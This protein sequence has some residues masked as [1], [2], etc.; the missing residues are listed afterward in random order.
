MLRIYINQV[1]MD[2]K[3]WIWHWDTL[4]DDWELFLGVTEQN[5]NPFIKNIGFV[6]MK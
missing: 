6:E 4:I 2:K 3:V 5:M 1:K